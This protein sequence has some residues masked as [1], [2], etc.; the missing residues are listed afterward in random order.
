MATHGRRRTRLDPGSRRKAGPGTRAVHAGEPARAGEPLTVPIYQSSAFL[1]DRPAYDDIAAGRH[2]ARWVYTRWGNPTAA[3]LEAK[4][5]ALE[6]CPA[7]VAVSSGMAAISATVLG[8]LGR[9][10]RVLASRD[11]YGGTLGFLRGLGARGIAADLADQADAAAMGRAMRK[12]TRL[13]FLESITNPLLRLPELDGIAALAAERGIPVAVDN[14]FATPVNLRPFCHGSSLVIHSATKYLGGHSDLVAGV[15]AGADAPLARVRAA[16]EEL[17]GTPDPHTAFLVSRGIKTLQLRMQRHNE[18][19]LAVAR[20]L[21]G[22]PR[23]A[24]VMYPGLESHPQHALARRLLDGFGGMVSFEIRGGLPA[25]M[26]FLRSLRLFLQAAT[27]GGVESLATVPALTSHAHL[28]PAERRRMGISDGLV[29]L[30]V[31]IEDIGD[32]V[33]DLERGLRGSRG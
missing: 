19:G 31:G 26:R 30:S 1:L 14:T 13:V 9:G 11:L 3:A 2:Q 18:N 16:N 24:R 20:L 17:G 12:G 32:L 29:R 7:A 23:V 21:E 4:V 33:E 10:D 28:P 8:L 22:H 15:V 5:A 6:G 27:L 25:A